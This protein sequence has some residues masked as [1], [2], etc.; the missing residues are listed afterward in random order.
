MAPSTAL[1]VADD[2]DAPDTLVGHLLQDGAPLV[3]GLPPTLVNALLQCCPGAAKLSPAAVRA[4][5]RV[6]AEAHPLLDGEGEARAAALREVLLYCM[7]DIGEGREQPESLH[8]TYSCC[9]RPPLF[10]SIRK[11]IV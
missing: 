9:S 2:H 3:Q 10:I 4:R 8:G 5:F 7:T 6:C 1:L 11:R